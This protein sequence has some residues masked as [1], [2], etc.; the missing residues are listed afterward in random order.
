M[1]DAIAEAQQIAV[2]R[3]HQA[4]GVAHLFK[5]LV[6]PGQLGRQLLSELGV[7]M[8]QLNRELDAELEAVSS[9]AGDSVT[10]GQNISPD[11]YQL[12]QKAEI[13]KK[14]FNDDYIATDTLVIALMQLSGNRLTDFLKAQGLTEQQVKK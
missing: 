3:K 7:E 2:T 12:L 9:V 14:D 4:I 10:Y 8:T 6:Q 5:Y 1:A 11:L 13:V